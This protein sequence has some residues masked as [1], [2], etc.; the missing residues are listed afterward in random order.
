M[1][2]ITVSAALATFAMAP[3][4]AAPFMAIGSSA[5]LF[6]TAKAGIDINDNVTLGSNYVAPGATQASNPV[7]DDVI[8]KFAPGLSYEFGK[9][10]LISGRLSYVES[11]ERYT[12]ND[13]LDSA[14]SDVSFVAQHKDEKSTTNLKASYRQLNQN[15]VD[16]RSPVLSRRDVVNVGG[17]HEME[18]SAK[19]SLQFGFDYTDT[20]YA[21]AS[22]AD[23]TRT[24]VPVNYFWE[25]TPKVD[26]SLGLRYREV[27]SD[28]LGVNADDWFYSIG[29]RGDFSPKL[30]GSFRLGVADRSLEVA[31]DRTTF[32]LGSDFT[33]L[34]SEKTTLTFGAANDFGTSGTGES[35][36]NLDLY[37]GLRANVS[38]SMT[39]TS[40]LS[41][42][43]IDY[44]TRAGDDYLEGTLGGEYTVNEY[45]KLLGSF[46]YSDNASGLAG[47]DFDNTIFSFSA[48]LRY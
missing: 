7:R 37:I 14:L 9:N 47:G 31:G 36:E 48:Q 26:L 11:F 29:A 34:Y 18:L 25:L 33:Y 45:L 46:K 39:L 41:Y 5:E 20:D 22:F 38:P 16:V 12:D 1:N 44:F 35:Q 8:W 32:G 43:Q 27:N 28:T 3:A 13:D 21:R 30:K 17:D 19:S 6:V 15:T 4:F 23:R 40:R 42:R 24:E 10:A 2:K